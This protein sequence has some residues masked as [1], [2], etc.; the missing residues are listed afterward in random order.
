MTKNTMA[1]NTNNTTTTNNNQQNELPILTEQQPQQQSI[2]PVALE[3][4][5]ATTNNN[6]SDDNDNNNNDLPPIPTLQRLTSGRFEIHD[7]VV[8]A[9][10]TTPAPAPATTTTTTTSS[11]QIRPLTQPVLDDDELF[12]KFGR[13]KK[14]SQNNNSN[15]DSSQQQQQQQQQPS[16]SIVTPPEI[17]RPIKMLIYYSVH[18]FTSLFFAPFQRTF[19][20]C[21][22]EKELIQRGLISKPFNGFWNCFFILGSSDVNFFRGAPMLAFSGLI[23]S[24]VKDSSRVFYKRILNFIQPTTTTTATTPPETSTIIKAVTINVL[25][26]CSG[27]IASYI[28]LQMYTQRALQISLIAATTAS[29]STTTTTTLSSSSSLQYNNL[30]QNVAGLSFA[31]AALTLD[32]ICLT[33]PRKEWQLFSPGKPIV[34]FIFTNTLNGIRWIVTPILTLV[35]MRLCMGGLQNMSTMECIKDVI[36]NTHY[37]TTKMF[38]SKLF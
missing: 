19:C 4:T 35:S 38:L 24:Q 26:E 23:Y 37:L 36:F 16:V 13:R 7:A 25:A 30:K 6:D 9:I 18:I 22:G 2:I 3:V 10:T 12:A 5:T 14:D 27:L 11:A 33:L 8:E 1:D 28:P 31:L 34:H 29:K 21:V 32:V 15:T 17:S 20:V